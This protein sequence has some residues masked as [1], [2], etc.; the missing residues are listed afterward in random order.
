MREKLRHCLREDLHF[1]WF[2]WGYI[3]CFEYFV[4]EQVG[5]REQVQIFEQVLYA[6][7]LR[8]LRFKPYLCFKFSVNVSVCVSFKSFSSPVYLLVKLIN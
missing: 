8:V 7:K 1:Y 2:Q 3:E 6:L 5:K 4:F